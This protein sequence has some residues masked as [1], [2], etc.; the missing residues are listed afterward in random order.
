MKYDVTF[1]INYT[2][3]DAV[4]KWDAIEQAEKLF[5]SDTDTH[6]NYDVDVNPIGDDE[7]DE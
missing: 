3:D 1:L 6:F 5:N 2:I 4:N 7:E